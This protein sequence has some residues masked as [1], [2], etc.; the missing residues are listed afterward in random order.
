MEENAVHSGPVYPEPLDAV[1][2]AGTDDNP[3]RMILGQN[4]AFLEIAGK[5]LVRHVVESLLA[6]KS[7]GQVFVVGP[8]E[9]LHAVLAGISPRVE[10]VPQKGKML[11]NAWAACAAAPT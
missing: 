9:R 6:S 11:A 1:V 2:L 10:L 8:L 4:K 3:K 7:V 5:A